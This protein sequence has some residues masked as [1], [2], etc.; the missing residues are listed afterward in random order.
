MAEVQTRHYTYG[1]RLFPDTP[2]VDAHTVISF[3]ITDDEMPGA[4]AR[5]ILD[6]HRTDITELFDLLDMLKVTRDQARAPADAATTSDA[7]FCR[8]QHVGVILMIAVSSAALV[9]GWSE[10]IYEFMKTRAKANIKKGSVGVGKFSSANHLCGTLNS[11]FHRLYATDGTPDIDPHLDSSKTYDFVHIKLY[12]T[13][14]AASDTGDADSADVS[15]LRF[16]AMCADHPCVLL[17][18][19]ISLNARRTMTSSIMTNLERYASQTNR[20]TVDLS[21]LV[22]GNPDGIFGAH[23]KITPANIPEW[24]HVY[25][26]SVDAM[27]HRQLFPDILPD[28]SIVREMLRTTPEMAALIKT[29][30]DAELGRRCL[31]QLPLQDGEQARITNPLA[32]THA[33]ADRVETSPFSMPYL[34]SAAAS[35]AASRAGSVSA[36]DVHQMLSSTFATCLRSMANRPSTTPQTPEAVAVHIVKQLSKTGLHWVQPVDRACKEDAGAFV[37]YLVN[38]FEGLGASVHH[39]TIGLFV[40]PCILTN[41]MTSKGGVHTCTSGYPGDGKSFFYNNILKL[42]FP[43]M[44]FQNAVSFSKQAFYSSDALRVYRNCVFFKDEFSKEMLDELGVDLFKMLLGANADAHRMTN[45]DFAT[46]N[47]PSEHTAKSRSILP[48]PLALCTASNKHLS[49]ILRGG[50]EADN[51]GAV[52]AAE[53]RMLGNVLPTV[54]GGIYPSMPMLARSSDSTRVAFLSERLSYYVAICMYVCMLI[55]NKCIDIPENIE[56]EAV[57]EQ[58]LSAVRTT[59]GEETDNKGRMRLAIQNLTL[60]FCVMRKVYEH[61][62][63]GGE[64]VESTNVEAFSDILATMTPTL[65]P[66]TTDAVMAASLV[67]NSTIESDEDAHIAQNLLDKVTQYSD[68]YDMYVVD[69]VAK[70]ADACKKS[71][72]QMHADLKRLTASVVGY[73]TDPLH[74]GTVPVYAATLD[75]TTET[76]RSGASVRHRAYLISSQY[77]KSVVETGLNIFD[78]FLC[79]ALV[80][81]SEKSIA[82]M[83]ASGTGGLFALPLPEDDGLLKHD[84]VITA[85]DLFAAFA[86]QTKDAATPPNIPFLIETVRKRARLGYIRVR[87]SNAPADPD[88]LYHR[89]TVATVGLLTDETLIITKDYF[90]RFSNATRKFSRTAQIIMKVL[91]T[92]GVYPLCVPSKA[93]MRVPEFVEIRAQGENTSTSVV[94]IDKNAASE[95]GGRAYKR[96]RIDPTETGGLSVFDGSLLSRLTDYEYEVRVNGLP[97]TAAFPSYRQVCKK[98]G[99][100]GAFIGNV[101][102]TTKSYTKFGLCSLSDIAET[103]MNDFIAD[104]VRRKLA[105]RAAA[106]DAAQA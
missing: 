106:A 27:N 14:Q 80:R 63:Q 25:Q 42:I 60:V 24:A 5:G 30:S 36:E 43:P 52:S 51:L 2:V 77:L 6:V 67:I 95:I 32:S 79:N 73:T 105:R 94:M 96:I 9:E 71:E 26:F 85:K 92:P 86:Y 99:T 49:T 39:T 23:G 100:T 93:D 78:S 20:A 41:F 4:D 81:F 90:N 84:F 89:L 22:F 91:D 101:L 98:L 21:W 65:V 28:I 56:Y 69:D 74:H 83:E 16:T 97:E 53:D 87:D 44:A 59:V 11:C 8:I 50:Q 64:R 103:P 66:T 38:G 54:K 1:K 55:S 12:A 40:L 47:E 31:L 70:L 18:P 58:I 7:F 102:P 10:R 48:S 13:V 104:K 72:D 15:A 88:W 33:V 29:M 68:I 3:I 37:A 19:F 75:C 35:I 57:V 62:V 76:S 82:E 45:V 61:F 46:G 17:N 34:T